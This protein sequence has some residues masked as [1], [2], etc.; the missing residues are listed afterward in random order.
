MSENVPPN[1][2]WPTCLLQYAPLVAIYLLATLLTGATYMGDTGDYVGSIT[3]RLDGNYY[4]F[5]EFGHLLWRPLGWL[6]YRLFHSLT[7]L[8]VG[9]NR[10]VNVAL[11]L[12]AISWLSGLAAVLLLC[13]LL[14]R[15]CRR[16]WAAQAVTFLF[17]C[18][19]AFLNY[20]QTGCP[21]VI[22][23][24]FLLL[25]L[26]LLVRGAERD[27]R[28]L[29]SGLGAGAALALSIC[30]WFPYFFSIPACL[31]APLLLN[32]Y[33]R[34]RGRLV[35]FC[36][37]ACGSLL[38]LVYLGVAV[39]SLGISDIAGL[40][41]WVT[42]ASHGVTIHGGLMRAIFGFAR[43]FINMGD[44]GRLFKRYL[45]HDPFSPV[46]VGD[47]FRLSLWKLGFFYLSLTAMVINLLR[48]SQ[49][50]RI[51]WLLIGGAL[52][53]S[54]FALILFSAGDT[55]RYLPLYPFF[56]LALG[57]AV[58]SDQALP[59][60]KHFLI[61]FIVVTGAVNLFALRQSALDREREATVARVK[62]LQ[63]RLRPGDVVAMSHFQDDLVTFNNNFLF[64]QIDPPIQSYQVLDPATTQVLSWRERFAAE[65]LSVWR[66][67]GRVWLSRRLLSERP[68]PEWNWVEGDDPAV[69]WTD[70]YRFFS[71]LEMDETVGGDDGF[72]L[73]ARS[74]ANEEMLTRV[75]AVDTK[76]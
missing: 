26:Y 29:W 53:L 57:W 71:T 52:P 8:F 2:R 67:G 20:M 11:V 6:C 9:T 48:S 49:G 17:I 43:S 34:E 41:A 68:R 63:P 60:M 4:E 45:M 54:V 62:E 36:A 66:E 42:K 40:R 10:D 51:L 39:I 74:P 18:S 25:G 15:I 12:C 76:R 13:A 38:A 46:S 28:L 64:N 55:E 70:F 59:M 73:L 69:S 35:V 19:N 32:G 58:S 50:K 37:L 31:L 33:T 5:W 72:V 56:F 24:A 22:G 27:Q 16:E 61:C 47:L 3:A 75:S 30:F 1:R 65:A 23:L 7:E 21:Y 14:R 44:D